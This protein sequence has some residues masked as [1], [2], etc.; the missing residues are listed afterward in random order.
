[1]FMLLYLTLQARA[2]WWVCLGYTVVA[3]T[4]LL[5]VFHYTL[6]IPWPQGVVVAPQEAV[7]GWLGG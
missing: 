6:H 4:F 2:P 1:L 7:L 5:G 3:L